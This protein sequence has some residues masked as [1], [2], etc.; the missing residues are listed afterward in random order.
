[1]AH[2]E[3][4]RQLAVQLASLASLEDVVTQG[5]QSLVETP[6][7]LVAPISS[8]EQGLPAALLRPRSRSRSYIKGN[9]KMHGTFWI[10]EQVQDEDFSI[11][12]ERLAQILARVQSLLQYCNVVQITRLVFHRP[13]ITHSTT[14]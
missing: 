9:A 8:A 13:W 3:Q 11:K 2:S 6:S 12:N 14:R 10:P 7:M 4:P 1:M 5:L